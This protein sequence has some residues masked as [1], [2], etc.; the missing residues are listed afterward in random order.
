METC[1][2]C[3]DHRSLLSSP[4]PIPLTAPSVRHFLF[5]VCFLLG[6]LSISAQTVIARWGKVSDED[7]AASSYLFAPG[8]EAVV[9][10]DVGKWVPENLEKLEARLFHHYQI[11]VL[12]K[13]A[14][15]KYGRQVIKFGKTERIR[16]LRAQYHYLENGK[17]KKVTLRVAGLP[18][19]T[20]HP[21]SLCK[22]VVFPEVPVDGI[23]EVR[24][25]LVTPNGDVLRP[26]YFEREIPTKYSEV[27]LFG[28]EPLAFRAGTYPNR[29]A[30]TS[31]NRW[32]KR[33]SPGVPSQ[34]FLT[35]VL[36]HRLHIRFQLLPW[37]PTS[38]EEDWQDLSYALEY[39]TVKSVDERVL[40]AL[41][42]LAL[43]LTRTAV[44]EEEKVAYIFHHLQRSVKWNGLYRRDVEKDPGAVYKSRKG[45]SAEI[46]MLLYLLLE[47]AGFQ[48]R[49]VFVSTRDHGATVDSPYWDQFNHLIIW[50]VV[51]GQPMFL[52]LSGGGLDYMWL[53]LASA[54][55]RGWV[56]SDSTTRGWIAIAPSPGSFIDHSL[57]LTL[58]E[59]AELNGQVRDLYAGYPEGSWN[60]SFDVGSF[61]LSSRDPLELYGDHQAQSPVTITYPA[62]ELLLPN[63]TPDSILV[64][65]DPYNWR[66]TLP[67]ID[68]SRTLPVEWEYPVAK[69]VEMVIS[70]PEGWAVSSLPTSPVE[71]EMQPDRMRFTLSTQQSV[72][73]V[74]VSWR[75]EFIE[76]T[77]QPL[78]IAE[79]IQFFKEVDQALSLNWTLVRHRP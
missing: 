17:K 6:Y 4:S 46:N 10:F 66:G 54:N 53:P 9:L 45:N 14:S 60:Q 77:L 12:T 43:T 70:V 41:G 27:L 40:Q 62:K 63:S 16:S 15:R 75:L 29:I 37:D 8:A 61:R 64:P 39:G 11:K 30:S 32:I 67:K 58:S 33:F 59:N 78:S 5:L 42:S 3:V 50:A 48:P 23:I 73:A 74:E 20:F 22:V 18:D 31:R 47:S 2:F 24:Y 51:D 35:N 55:R 1:L 79:L 38:E 19:S 56:I 7:L 13:E 65:I 25:S 72:D 71:L 52:D 34:P 69:S 76:P 57:D 36:D 26:W 49:R 28:F 21:D 68:A 44:T